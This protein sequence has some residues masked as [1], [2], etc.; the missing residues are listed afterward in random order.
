MTGRLDE[1]GQSVHMSAVV[2][3]L[4]ANIFYLFSFYLGLLY[5]GTKL[6]EILM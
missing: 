6:Y 1:L 2:D 4:T 5:Q 3:G